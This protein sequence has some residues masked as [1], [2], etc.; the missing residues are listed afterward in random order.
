M[1]EAKARDASVIGI[2]DH[3]FIR[4]IYLRDPNGYVIELTAP[5]AGA[6]ATAMDARLAREELARWS[7]RRTAS[8]QA[9]R[10]A[11]MAI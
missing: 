4:S 8:R 2:A 6:G 10:S 3:G 1:Q 5:V 9:G 11:S 7:Q